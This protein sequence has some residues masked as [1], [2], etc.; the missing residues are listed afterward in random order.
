L[1][2]NY[3]EEYREYRELLRRIWETNHQSC[4]LLL[5]RE[6]PSEMAVMLGNNSLIHSLA[7]VGLGEGGREI[8]RARGLS[9]E[10]RWY[11]AIEYLGGNPAYL[12]SVSIA[13]KKL[14]GGKV[15]EFCKHEELFLTEEIESLLTH[16]FS[17][18]S[19]VE[20]EVIKLLSVEAA[21]IDISR[22]ILMLRGYANELLNISPADVG[23][24]IVSL[25]RRGLIVRT[26]TDGGAVFSL[27]SI[28]K[29]FILQ[30]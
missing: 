10:D 23:K 25:G 26:E 8:F 27:G 3:A 16:Q 1:A 2:G 13:I 5:S 20:Q 15:S 12:E 29:K 11:Y 30:L 6:E 14:F 19:T 21:P 22:S 7:L 24:A 17:R 18:L 4:L 9:D 28:V